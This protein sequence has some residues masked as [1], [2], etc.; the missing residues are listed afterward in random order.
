M[1]IGIMI[2]TTSRGRNWKN[3][4]ETHLYNIFLKSFLTTYDKEHTYTIYLATDDDDIVMNNGKAFLN[5]FRPFRTNLVRFRTVF[6][7]INS[8]S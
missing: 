3:I 1:K 2:P 4:K 6:G 5:R 8:K 7:R